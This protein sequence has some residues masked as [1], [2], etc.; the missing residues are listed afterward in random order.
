MVAVKVFGCLLII[1]SGY[2][3]SCFA[4]AG[5]N[6][7]IQRLRSL[8]E[9]LKAIKSRIENYCMPT[10]EIISELPRELFIRC[11][12]DPEVVPCNVEMLVNECPF[13]EDDEVYSFFVGFFSSLGTSYKADE[14]VRCK[15]ACDDIDA[16][17]KR[18]CDESGK[19]QRTVPVLSLCVSVV[20]AIIVL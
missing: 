10:N 18:R 1:M 3:F 6:V 17:I 5:D 9:L 15:L 4:L 16:I 7:S 11:G 13:C 20:I 12:Y 14:I 2:F 19:R 8:E